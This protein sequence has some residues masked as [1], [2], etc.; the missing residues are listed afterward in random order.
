MK[1]SFVV[2]VLAVHCIATAKAPSTNK[3]KSNSNKWKQG[4]FKP[5][6]ASQ[7]QAG[8]VIQVN[9]R[10]NQNAQPNIT[11]SPTASPKMT[12]NP[13]MKANM[14]SDTNVETETSNEVLVRL[15]KLESEVIIAEKWLQKLKR[16][17]AEKAGPFIPLPMLLAFI[18]TPIISYLSS[19]K[20]K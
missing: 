18:T 20:N 16:L 15:E 6:I 4:E 14:S 8:D 7:A 2:L 5:K 13:K 10:P 1:R 3:N 19:K 12:A 17:E 11:A 9:V